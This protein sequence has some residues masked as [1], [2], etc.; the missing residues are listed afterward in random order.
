MEAWFSNDSEAFEAYRLLLHTGSQQALIQPGALD[1]P[2]WTQN[3]FAGLLLQ[4]KRFV[5]ASVPQMMIPFFQ[6]PSGKQFVI[7]LTALVSGSISLVLRDLNNKGE[8]KDRNVAGWVLDAL[9]MSGLASGLTELDATFSALTG[10]RGIKRLL[11]GEDYTRWQ[12]RQRLEGLAGPSARTLRLF[13][14]AM[15]L[16][17]NAL[18]PYET[19]AERQISAVRRLIPILSSNLF[20]RHPVDMVEASLGGRQNTSGARILKAMRE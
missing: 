11:T 2:M 18:S 16:P 9:D 6:Q 10:A 1:S 19:V 8:V 5:I 7:G 17:Y 4:F 3:A 15:W 20:L 13:N 12:E 14:D